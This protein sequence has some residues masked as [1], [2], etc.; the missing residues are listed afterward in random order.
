MFGSIAQRLQNTLNQ[1]ISTEF[2]ECRIEINSVLLGLCGPS[3]MSS[4]EI[5]TVEQIPINLVAGDNEVV[6][7]LGDGSLTKLITLEA[8]ED[9]DIGVSEGD[10]SNLE[11]S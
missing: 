10:Y 9:S 1:E 8:T 11:L 4:K 5:V 2:G 6:V 7:S 3:S